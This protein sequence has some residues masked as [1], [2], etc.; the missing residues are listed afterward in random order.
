[1]RRRALVLLA[2]AALVVAAVAVVSLVRGADTPPPPRLGAGTAAPGPL[3]GTLRPAAGS[4][5]GYRVRETVA[6]IGL[7]V[8]V[9]RTGEVR[10]SARFA[11]GRIVGARFE[12]DTRTLRSDEAG[13]DEALRTRGLETDRYQVSGFVLGPPARLA[14]RFTATGTLTLHGRART[15]R[16]A[17]RSR[18]V[19]RGVDLVGA[20]PIR[21][22][23]YGMRPPSVAGVASVR[24][25]GVME[26]RL[27]LR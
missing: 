18:R 9:G 6:G 20:T 22:A 24:D 12:A 4:F 5:V 27:R 21:F 3:T 19:G 15:V 8:A 25:H 13:R 16:V 14:P 23:D 11:G 10:G 2:A 17:L 7:N 26:F 1:V